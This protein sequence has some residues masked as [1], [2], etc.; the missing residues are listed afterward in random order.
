MVDYSP[1]ITS[2]YFGQKVVDCRIC[3]DPN[4]VLRFAFVEFYREG[5]MEVFCIGEH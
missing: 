5:I 3:G 4:S 2:C 1:K